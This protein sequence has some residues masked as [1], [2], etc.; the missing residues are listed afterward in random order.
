MFKNYNFESLLQ[1]FSIE[2]V[3]IKEREKQKE[4]N[5]LNLA[6]QVREHCIEPGADNNYNNRLLLVTFDLLRIVYA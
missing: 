2:H 4:T 3:L 5:G 6:E 1:R